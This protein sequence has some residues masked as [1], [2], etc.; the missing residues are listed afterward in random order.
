MEETE[1]RVIEGILWQSDATRID[2]RGDGELEYLDYALLKG[3]ANGKRIR[4]TV[5]V[6]D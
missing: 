2:L 6:L 3:I 1:V 4:L 5:Q